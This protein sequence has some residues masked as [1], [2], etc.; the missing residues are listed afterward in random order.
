M[1]SIPPE[2]QPRVK[3]F[4]PLVLDRSV[5]AL[6]LLRE[7]EADLVRVKFIKDNYPDEILKYNA[8]IEYPPMAPGNVTAAEAQ[9]G[10][11]L[12]TAADA[13]VAA[14]AKRLA[15][16]DDPQ[17]V[18]RHEKLLAATQKP[19]VGGSFDFDGVHYQFA[20]LHASVIRRFLA[21]NDRLAER[22]VVHIYPSRFEIIIDLNLE[23]PRGREVAR[24]WVLDNIDNAKPLTNE[25]ERPV[26]SYFWAPDSKQILFIQD[27]GGDENFL[28]YGVDVAT[29]KQTTLTPFTK[30]RAQLV[31][32]SNKH[33]E[34]V[35]VGLN[36]RDAKWH[37]V[38]SLNLKT[39]MLTLV[40]KNDGYAGFLADHVPLPNDPP[41]TR[42]PGNPKYLDFPF[43][44]DSY[45]TNPGLIRLSFAKLGRLHPELLMDG[46]GTVA[47]VQQIGSIVE[48]L[49]FGDTNP[50]IVAK[51]E[52]D[53]I[54]SA[55]SV[56]ID[57]VV[58]LRFPREFVGEYQLRPGS[59][60]VSVNCYY[61]EGEFA[62]DLVR[63]P[64][65]LNWL[66]VIPMVADFLADD[67]E[68]LVTLKR[69]IPDHAWQRC[70]ELTVAK[71]KTRAYPRDGRPLGCERPVI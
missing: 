40:Q 55:Y 20:D 66:N 14:S 71:L 46:G 39:G 62:P 57:C 28:L 54:V 48:Q 4:D 49:L 2:E 7:M 53:L 17:Q 29:G 52:P 22:A 10:R 50:A 33:K 3:T 44:E 25:R 56:D 61:G 41:G 27:K 32:S 13:A 60:L 58:F 42:T 45:A 26:R 43:P 70:K 1:S 64:K 9:V 69:S 59:K 30:T 37:D 21:A 15:A 34:R 35:L 11:M 63:G 16:S 24:Q 23:H 47:G 6:P 19:Q 36:N 31:G 68:R 38:Y 8:A 12:K 67:Q 5:I 65:Y 18:A 51:V